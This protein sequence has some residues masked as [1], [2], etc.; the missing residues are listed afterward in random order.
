MKRTIYRVEEFLKLGADTGAE[1]GFHDT[2]FSHTLNRGRQFQS[3]LLTREEQAFADSLQLETLVPQNSY[4]NCQMAA[5]R[6]L[7]PHGI[8]LQYVE[9]FIAVD[10][11][12]IALHRA[13]LSVN[14][15]VW[16]LNT[17]IRPVDADVMGIIPDGWAYFGVEM[18][19]AE[20]RHAARH[21]QGAPII[22]DP[23]CG[24]PKICEA[25]TSSA[26]A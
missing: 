8:T 6:L 26:S 17:V 5:L 1:A 7:P 23:N 4:L 2:V 18:D 21:W 3:S 24:W 19:P 11:I 13:W 9:G 15:K 25:G 14:G 12:P 20:C 16:D 22:D 10:G